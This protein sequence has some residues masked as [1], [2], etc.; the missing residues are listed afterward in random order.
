MFYVVWKILQVKLLN[1]ML[2]HE[3]KICDIKQFKTV[4][5]NS[6]IHVFVTNF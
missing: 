6:E 1:Y 5:A 2:E 3:P 4:T